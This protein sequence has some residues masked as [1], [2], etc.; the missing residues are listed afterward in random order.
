MFGYSQNQ[1]RE[2]CEDFRELRGD[3]TVVYTLCDS[4]LTD[5]L[6]EY[7]KKG[8]LTAIY[9][10]SNTKSNGIIEYTWYNHKKF[11]M[12]KK[13][14]GAFTLD[15]KKTGDWKHFKKNDV[16]W[17][18]EVYKSDVRITWIRYNNHGEIIWERDY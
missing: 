14:S 9:D 3:Y 15:N 12:L 13:T 17:D 7:D 6:F 10:Y 1:A 18:Y 16:L 5:T 11:D 2:Y 8:R 4:V